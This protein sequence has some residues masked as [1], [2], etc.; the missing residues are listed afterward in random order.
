MATPISTYMY[1]IYVHVRSV[2]I[3]EWTVSHTGQCGIRPISRVRVRIFMS[4]R[5]GADR[6]N[7]KGRLFYRCSHTHFRPHPL[8]GCTSG[9]TSNSR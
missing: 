7:L 2:L 3:G 9:S 1:I 8:Q 6:G 5:P 4:Q